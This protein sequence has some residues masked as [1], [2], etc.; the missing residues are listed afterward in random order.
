MAVASLSASTLFAQTPPSDG[1]TAVQVTSDTTEDDGIVIT[2]LEQREI[3]E[4]VDVLADGAGGQIPRWNTAFCLAV[5]GGGPGHRRLIVDTIARNAT[6]VGVKMVSDDCTPEV[7]IVL[8]KDADTFARDFLE[9]NPRLYKNV[10]LYGLPQPREQAAWIDPAPVR[11]LVRSTVEARLGS[12]SHITVPVR[13]SKQEMMVLVDLTK[14]EGK[15]WEQLADHLAMVVLATPRP[16]A[17]GPQDSIMA[18]FDAT[19]GAGAPAG[20]TSLDRLLLKGLYVT[21]EQVSGRWQR[22]DIVR[23]IGHELRQQNGVAFSGGE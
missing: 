9:A 10:G 4:K 21:G 13:E 7:R 16:G 23:Y 3:G 1:S 15:T 5:Y 8:T 18:L 22:D 12:A 2:A 6:D 11:W 14:C 17:R 19:A 20:M